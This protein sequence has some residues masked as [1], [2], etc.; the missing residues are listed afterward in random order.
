MPKF[1][2]MTSAPWAEANFRMPPEDNTRSPRDSSSSAG[3]QSPSSVMIHAAA[4][5]FSGSDTDYNPLYDRQP[6]SDRLVGLDIE[7]PQWQKDPEKR[8][9][10]SYVRGKK[11]IVKLDISGSPNLEGRTISVKVTPS[12]ALCKQ[13]FEKDANGKLVKD[14]GKL[15]AEDATGVDP[16]PITFEP[17]CQTGQITNW[18]HLDYDLL[19]FTTSALPNTVRFDKLKIDWCFEYRYNEQDE[20]QPAGTERTEHETYITYSR[21]YEEFL[22]HEY[23]WKQV[24]RRACSYAY[25]TD[26]IAETATQVTTGIY[27]SLE[28]KYD[29]DKTHSKDDNS[30][31]QLWEM[32]RE[33]QVDCMDGSNYWTIMMRWL[34]ISA[35]Q[36][37]I[38]TEDHIRD[39][40]LRPEV[41]RGFFYNT[42]RP[43][44]TSA[45]NMGWWVRNLDVRRLSDDYNN[46]WNF[47]QV[48][49]VAHDPD[50]VANTRHV[51]DPII[52][53]DR[54]NSSRV[55]VQM[56]QADYMNAVFDPRPPRNPE[57]LRHIREGEIIIVQIIQTFPWDKPALVREVK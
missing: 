30:E 49:I 20:W 54:G 10:I 21:S 41:Y 8:D 51:Y 53:I 57:L 38:N 32:L 23:P 56:T 26:T 1:I 13:I 3:S 9:P 35:N 11:A 42:L 50:D 24:L 31:I 12:G 19:S 34:G 43:I 25:G 22:P 27:D 4:I 55:P 52:K 33:G 48:G 6:T 37:K 36:I 39:R 17:P 16:Y 5:K 40:Q 2:D 15:V 47:H 7:P 46:W 18:T 45:N 44:S 29:G 14:A 28:F